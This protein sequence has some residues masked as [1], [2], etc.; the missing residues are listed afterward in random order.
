[1][2]RF[3]LQRTS[4]PTPPCTQ[5]APQRPVILQIIDIT[6]VCYVCLWLLCTCERKKDAHTKKCHSRLIYKKMHI[7]VCIQKFWY[8]GVYTKKV[9]T[10]ACIQKKSEKNVCFYP[11]K[12]HSPGCIQKTAPLF[13][14]TKKGNS[15]YK[16]VSR[17][18]AASEEI[19]RYIT[20]GV[21][22]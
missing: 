16:K 17:D 9:N 7:S 12:W 11:K 13:L 1:M 2:Y 3:I 14:Y 19:F 15:L 10:P 5:R 18:L 4:S 20:C 21:I 22:F 8:S 6:C